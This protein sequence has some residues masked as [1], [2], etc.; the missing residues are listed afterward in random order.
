MDFLVSPSTSPELLAEGYDEPDD[1]HDFDEPDE[2]E[3]PDEAEV[4]ELIECTSESLDEL[5]KIFH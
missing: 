4:W 5:T 1:D 2:P 3:D